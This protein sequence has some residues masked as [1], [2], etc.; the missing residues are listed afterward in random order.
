[1]EGVLAVLS[2]LHAHLAEADRGSRVLYTQAVALAIEKITAQP[3]HRQTREVRLLAER[4]AEVFAARVSMERAEEYA[5]ADRERE[6]RKIIN[7]KATAK[8]INAAFGRSSGGG[9]GGGDAA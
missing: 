3:S 9:R 6:R 1:M 8:R 2:A 5:R 7:F 4:V